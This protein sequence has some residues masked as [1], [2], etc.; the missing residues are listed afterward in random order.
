MD[1]SHITEGS[2]VYL[3]VLKDGGYL[4]LEDIHAVMALNLIGKWGFAKWLIHK[5]Q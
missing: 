1:C 4:S 5:R 2:T 3:P